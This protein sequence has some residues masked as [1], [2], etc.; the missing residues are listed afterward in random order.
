MW[1]HMLKRRLVLPPLALLAP[2][3]LSA[4]RRVVERLALGPQ[5]L[6]SMWRG[7][8][9]S[10][11]RVGPLLLMRETMRCVAGDDGRGE[12]SE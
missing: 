8:G 5:P 11:V 3:A 2:L 7:M 9:D 1:E 4:P 10:S 12:G 6:T